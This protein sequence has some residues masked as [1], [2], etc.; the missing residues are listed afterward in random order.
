MRPSGQR[1]LV[2]GGAGFLG[3]HLCEAL[4]RR[5]DQVLCVDNFH[6]GTRGA[7]AALLEHPRFELLQHDVTVPLDVE[8]DRIFNLACPASPVHYQHDPVRTTR[9]CVLGAM[10]LL[11][12]AERSR[13]RILQASTSE[14]YGDPEVHPQ[15]ESYWGRVNPTGLRSCYNEGKRCAETLFFDYWRQHRH[16]RIAHGGAQLVAQHVAIGALDAGLHHAGGKQHQRDRA[17]EVQQDDGA[18]HGRPRRA[19]LTAGKGVRIL[20]ISICANIPITIS[21]IIDFSDA[22][23][24]C[25][26]RRTSE[27]NAGHIG[28]E[29]HGSMPGAMISQYP[30]S[31][32]RD[33]KMY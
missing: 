32:R 6:T 9:T 22:M 10:N 33:L 24:V 3:S 30:A 4:I 8:V 25:A 26:R 1:T 27:M 20:F 18:A 11:A 23:I 13:A 5:G 14:V 16:D 12:L 31:V 15:P 17:G 21:R 28:C 29:P 7:I 2:T 19:A